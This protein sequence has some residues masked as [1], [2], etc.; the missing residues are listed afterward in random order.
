MDIKTRMVYKE[1]FYLLHT[2]NGR[3]RKIKKGEKRERDEEERKQKSARKRAFSSLPCR[4]IIYH[5][6]D[7]VL[8][9]S[10]ITH[11]HTYIE[12]YTTQAKQLEFTGKK[13]H[14]DIAH[15]SWSRRR[16]VGGREESAKE[17]AGGERKKLF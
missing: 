2:H 8:P 17:R 11:T 13:Q 3:S 10:Y 7:P 5:Y 4:T 15:A 1:Y 14:S 9:P 16:W 12:K 6:L